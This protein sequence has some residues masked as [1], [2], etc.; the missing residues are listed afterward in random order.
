[1]KELN[2]LPMTYLL[3]Y[4]DL[5]ADGYECPSYIRYDKQAEYGCG[6]YEYANFHQDIIC[7]ELKT[8]MLDKKSLEDILSMLD[9]WK[10]CMDESY[11]RESEYYS[12]TVEEIK[13]LLN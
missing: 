7:A 8:W 13:K 9:D 6:R 1:M 5:Y 11:K 3:W 2:T 4:W 12:Y 10:S